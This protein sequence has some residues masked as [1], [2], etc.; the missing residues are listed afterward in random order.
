MNAIDSLRRGIEEG[1]WR[2]VCDGLFLLTG[3]R[4][5]EPKSSFLLSLRKQID[6]E[7]GEKS[8]S[9]EDDP[10]DLVEDEEDGLALAEQ[11]RVDHDKG[12]GKGEKT[13]DEPNRFV[14]DG[15]L[16]K[17]D[18]AASKKQSKNA[19]AKEYRQPFRLVK[20]TCV[21]CKR[22][23]EVHP[24][25]APRKLPGTDDLTT[26]YCDDCKPQVSSE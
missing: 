15:K 22:H 5:A 3:E 10:A 8:L 7:L 13:E 2:L 11:F 24:D 6:D 17:K 16:A 9:Y 23:R 21:A 1:K 18:I 14:D 12:K 26:F 4:L 19:A 20:A 25:L